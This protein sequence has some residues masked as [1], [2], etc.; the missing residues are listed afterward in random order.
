MTIATSRSTFSPMDPALGQAL[1]ALRSRLDGD[2]ITPG[3]ERYDDARKVHDITI[4]RR[5]LAIV[6]AATAGDVAEAVR[7]ARRQGQPLAV[8]SG[9]H[10]V[11]G[12]SMVDGAV[13]IDLSAMKGMSID[14]LR[15]VARVQPGVTSETWRAPPTPTA[16]RSR[17]VTLRPLRWAA[18][19][20]AAAWAGWCASTVSPSIT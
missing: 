14:P 6:R 10:S 3:A 17:P 5:P 2:L 8:R 11:A 7:F 4:D 20:R 16:L 9:G 15:R 1:D 12:H 18:W 19:S 13:V